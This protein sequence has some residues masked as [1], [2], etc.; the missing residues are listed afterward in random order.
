MK[1][2][3]ARVSTAEQNLDLQLDALKAAGC[4]RIYEEHA[5]GK[6]AER[7]ELVN[8]L[9]ALRPGDVLVVWRL[10]RLG[11]NLA[12]LVRIVGELEAGQVGQVGLESL[13]ERLETISSTGRLVFHIFAVLAEFE[14]NVTRERTLAGLKAAR[15]RGRLGGRP[16]KLSAKDKQQIR[17]LLKDPAVRVKDVAKRFGVSVTT[18]YKRV[19]VVTPDP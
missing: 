2:G 18:L 11:R 14:R 5:S 7:P 17:V 15:A 8:C 19:G 10:D 13:T 9:K 1:I 3:Y 16:E 12:D 6:H 4:Q